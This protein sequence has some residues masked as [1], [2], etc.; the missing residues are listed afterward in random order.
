MPHYWKHMKASEAD[1]SSL[2]LPALAGAAQEDATQAQMKPVPAP[3]TAP[4][5]RKP[6]AAASGTDWPLP[7]PIGDIDSGKPAIARKPRR[8]EISLSRKDLEALNELHERCKG[9][10]VKIRKDKLL[11][12]G[13]Q[14]L[15][16]APTGKLLAILG[17]L[18]SQ[19]TVLKRKKKKPPVRG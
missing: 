2:E 1:R 4:I 11:A 18:E 14:L 7:P 12:A 17:P 15:A 6:L 3:G 5:Q 19:S 10:G 13:L 9:F 8:E 16:Q